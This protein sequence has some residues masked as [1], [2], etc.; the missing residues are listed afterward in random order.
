MESKEVEKL[1]GRDLSE[2]IAERQTELPV[3]DPTRARTNKFGVAADGVTLVT[4]IEARSQRDSQ[5]YGPYPVY[6]C[7]TCNASFRL[8]R[9]GAT[10]FFSHPPQKQRCQGIVLE[11]PVHQA[12]KHA[13]ATL[14]SQ[15]EIEKDIRRLGRRPDVYHA[16]TSTAVEIVNSGDLNTYGR[17]VEEYDKAGFTQAW[18]FNSAHS[19]ATRFNTETLDE[20]ALTTEGVVRVSGLFTSRLYPLFRKIGTARCYCFYRG[21]IFLSA[22]EVDCWELLDFNHQFQHVARSDEWGI[23]KSLIHA[24]RDYRGI[25]EDGPETP[26]YAY[27]KSWLDRLRYR[28]K[29][30]TTWNRD[31]RDLIE[32]ILGDLS[33]KQSHKKIRRRIT[34]TDNAPVHTGTNRRL[35]SPRDAHSERIGKDELLE[36]IRALDTRTKK[37]A[38]QSEDQ[39]IEVTEKSIAV[40]CEVVTVP[41]VNAEPERGGSDWICPVVPILHST[42]PSHKDQHF[43]DSALSR[44]DLE[45]QRAAAE[46]TF[47]RDRQAKGLLAKITS[48]DWERDGEG[49]LCRLQIRLIIAGDSWVT[50]VF[51]NDFMG[52]LHQLLEATDI[53]LVELLQ[54]PECLIGHRVEVDWGPCGGGGYK[55]VQK[56]YPPRQAV[57]PLQPPQ[58]IFID[59]H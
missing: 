25:V 57:N 40:D 14:G 6:K 34:E 54:D 3:K 27:A 13:F 44:G 8:R 15:W 58:K 21:F 33:D 59:A 18:I 28:G 39:T 10:D 22:A 41:T 16:P 53:S 32:E 29:N 46:A 38:E 35:A 47:V 9:L 17:K 24:R 51:R 56:F 2:R 5:G 19:A 36:A 12:I 37:V 42:M 11:S 43:R 7:P 1:E 4:A 23:Q 30:H 52:R 20:S 55:G 48:A 50:G 49:D 45:Q 26:G 31:K